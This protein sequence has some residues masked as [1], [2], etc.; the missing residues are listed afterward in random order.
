[1]L[2]K[3]KSTATNMLLLKLVFFRNIYEATNRT[4]KGSMAIV[5]TTNTQQTETHEV[6]QRSLEAGQTRLT[7]LREVVLEVNSGPLGGVPP[8]ESGPEVSPVLNLIIDRTAA[9]VFR[10]KGSLCL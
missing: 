8:G 6:D 5:L 10:F 1:M 3:C 7:V 4:G 9:W 2:L